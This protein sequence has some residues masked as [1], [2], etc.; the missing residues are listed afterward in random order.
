[1]NVTVTKSQ[2]SGALEQSANLLLITSS[3]TGIQRLRNKL[4]E[5]Y[6]MIAQ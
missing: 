5:N 1:M 6:A 2:T 3:K 4:A